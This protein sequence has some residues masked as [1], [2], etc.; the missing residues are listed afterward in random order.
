MFTFD[1]HKREVP[2]RCKYIRNHA[3]LLLLHKKPSVMQE[4][5]KTSEKMLRKILSSSHHYVAEYQ[6]ICVYAFFKT[7]FPGQLITSFCH[8]NIT[9][10]TVHTTDVD[11]RFCDG[12]EILTR[13]FAW[14]VYELWTALLKHGFL[15]VNTWLLI[16]HGTTFYALIFS[17]EAAIQNQDC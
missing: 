1:E 17:Q 11:M 15:P 12:S 14:Q 9:V 4:Y 8:H 5:S 3:W 2:S 7:Q 13:K 6:V 10:V 16:S